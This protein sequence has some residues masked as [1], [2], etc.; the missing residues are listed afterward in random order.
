MADTEHN[1]RRAMLKALPVGL[2]A[3]L[4]AG[5]AAEAADILLNDTPESQILH[6]AREIHRV[7][8]ETQPEGAWL[9]GFYFSCVGGDLIETSVWASTQ[10]E[11]KL[12][13]ARPAVLASWRATDG[14][15][16]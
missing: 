1:T 4:T 2:M 11:H 15:A 16:V 6:H 12:M 10:H 3:A 5:N 7:L 8:A 13:H 9:R 14:S